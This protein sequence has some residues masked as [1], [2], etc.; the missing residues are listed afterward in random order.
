MKTPILFS[1]LC[2]LSLTACCSIEDPQTFVLGPDPVAPEFY[3]SMDIRELQ[4]DSLNGRLLALRYK[5]QRIYDRMLVGEIS[6]EDGQ[7]QI[8]RINTGIEK[9]QEIIKG[10]DTATQ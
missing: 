3:N 5:V 6:E 4:I 10:L 9:I 1:L 8:D 2:L 7:I